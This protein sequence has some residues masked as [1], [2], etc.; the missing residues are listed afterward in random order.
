MP[1][2]RG[3][4]KAEARPELGSF[5]RWI[6]YRPFPSARNGEELAECVVSGWWL[7]G[8]KHQTYLS[9]IGPGHGMSTHSSMYRALL[10]VDGRV[11]VF[12]ILNQVQGEESAA[13]GNLPCLGYVVSNIG[14]LIDRKSEWVGPSLLHFLQGDAG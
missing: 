8:V 12:K 7:P 3:E 9:D 11:G 4:R 5:V 13:L 2:K 10:A 1:R 14:G 6:R